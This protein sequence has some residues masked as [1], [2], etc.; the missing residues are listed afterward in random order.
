MEPTR[1]T[2][3]DDSEFDDP[4]FDAR[5]GHDTPSSEERILALVAHL[6]A[7]VGAAVIAPLV[8]YLL[9]KD[10]SPFVA[11]QA[12]EALNFHLTMILAFIV[13]G[14]LT[15]VLI[16]VLFLI[17]LGIGGVVLSIIAAVKAND[18]ERYRYPFTLRLVK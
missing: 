13:A 17:V 12:R 14:I 8:I 2:A 7:L 9:K 15:I 3:F 10:T 5:Y 1:S 16:G 4:H 18:G 11:D 6:S